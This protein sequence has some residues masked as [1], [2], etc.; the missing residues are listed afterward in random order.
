M[1]DIRLD[2]YLYFKG[3]CREA[4]EFYKNIFGGEIDAMAYDQVPQGVPGAD[5]M[6]KDWIMHA[7]LAGGD[8]EL[9]ASDTLH[10]S[11]KVAKI[12]LSLGGKDETKMKQVFDMLSKGGMVHQPLQKQF[13]GDT[14]GSLTDKYGVNWMVNVDSGA[15]N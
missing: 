3:Q 7:R 5:D 1:G 14:F 9:V 15:N 8:I 13:W 11:D 10:A 6:S 2:V 12:D 4:L